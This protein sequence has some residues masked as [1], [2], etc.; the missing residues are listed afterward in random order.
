VSAASRG[1]KARSRSRQAVEIGGEW[2]CRGLP[3]VTG[4]RWRQMDASIQRSVDANSKGTGGHTLRFEGAP[5]TDEEPIRSGKFG[6]DRL[7]SGH[8]EQKVKVDAD[9]NASLF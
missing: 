4:S 9:R 2:N 1:K 8:I 3:I 7:C 6:L 5:G